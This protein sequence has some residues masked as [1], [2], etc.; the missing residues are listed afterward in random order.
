MGI[1]YNTICQRRTIRRFQQKPLS[2]EMLIKFVNA[3]RLAPSASNIQPCE[4]V[5][6]NDKELLNE[7]FPF[8]RWAGYIAPAGDP[9]GN[10]RPVAY[11]VVLVNISR[12]KKGGEIDAAAGIENIL[13][14]AWEEG[15]GSCWLGSIDR[16]QITKVLRIPHYLKINSIIALGYPN[17]QPVIEDARGSI[18]YWKNEQ[19]ILHVPKRKLEEVCYKNGY[20]SYLK[21]ND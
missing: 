13:L 12:Q 17:E 14:A 10:E 5:I 19:G 16:K 7:I 2:E 3:A 4:Y 11:I 8:L 9:A 18:K 6:V 1:V 20:G 15:I 21:Q